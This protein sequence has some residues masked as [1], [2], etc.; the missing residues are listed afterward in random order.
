MTV[1]GLIALL[2]EL[3]SPDAEVGIYHA[4]LESN[5][6]VTGVVVQDRARPEGWLYDTLDHP[7]DDFGI[8]NADV[9]VTITGS[10]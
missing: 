5:G 1:A 7:L 10:A 8:S 6:H 9:I 4:T 3:H 2:E